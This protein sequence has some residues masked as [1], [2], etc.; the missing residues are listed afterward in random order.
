MIDDIDQAAACVCVH[1]RG[2][3]LH[4][5]LAGNWEEQ[6]AGQG[7]HRAPAT[8]T[9]NA[10]TPTACRPGTNLVIRAPVVIADADHGVGRWRGQYG[11]AAPAAAETA[12]EEASD[13]ATATAAAAGHDG[14]WRRRKPGPD[15]T[16]A[17]NGSAKSAAWRHA[18]RNHSTD[19]HSTHTHTCTRARHTHLWG[20]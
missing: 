1:V 11:G 7:Q 13:A 15:H 16:D 5:S 3:L 19:T 10:S 14:A 18:H 2:H 20:A 8:T 6:H 4:S 9:P 17:G 12:E